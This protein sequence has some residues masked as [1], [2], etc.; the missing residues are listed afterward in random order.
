MTGLYVKLDAEYA[1]DDK[2]I[3]A[4]PMAE[5]LYIRGLCFAKRT[6]LDGKITRSQ[7]TAVGINI[8]NVTKHAQSLV[9]VGAW[10]VTSQGWQ[11]TTWLKRNKSASTI[12]AEAE[13][14][15]AQSLQANHDR[16]HIK[17]NKPNPTCSLC[18][19]NWEQKFG[20]KTDPVSDPQADPPATQTGSDPVSTET[21][22]ETQPKP[23]AEAKPQSK[24]SSSSSEVKLTLAGGTAVDD[25]RFQQ[26]LDLVVE[27][28]A[29][30][31]PPTDPNAWYPTVRANTLTELGPT[32][33][34]M[35]E[36][37]RSPFEVASELV[38]KIYTRQAS[39]KAAS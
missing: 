32:I 13:A 7:L 17:E 10:T 31:N 18:D 29:A 30:K 5:L 27:A 3:E 8:P 26:A 16:W 25:D 14:K 33:R 37:G 21:K 9:D 6:L 20:P 28:K 35:V 1:S 15:R 34:D 4:G 2:L 39:R 23:E 11:I 19:P 12:A 36:R 22:P 38:G 24:P